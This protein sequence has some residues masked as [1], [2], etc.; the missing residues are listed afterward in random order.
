MLVA[1]LDI[2]DSA[3]AQ[4]NLGD[5]WREKVL[6]RDA[7][8]NLAFGSGNDTCC[9]KSCRCTINRPIRAACDFMEGSKR[10]TA[11]RQV[12]ID[13]INPEWQDN[14]LRGR[15]A[16]KPPDRLAKL[17]DHRIVD[18]LAHFSVRISPPAF[19]SVQ[20]GNMFPLC[21]IRLG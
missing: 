6:S 16:F 2:D 12:P 3:R 19:S 1:G 13:D 20:T 8:E 15:S 5:R 11:T 14:P 10:Q 18:S 9:K 7:P 17:G 21:S 4:P